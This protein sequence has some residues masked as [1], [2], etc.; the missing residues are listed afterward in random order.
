M[1]PFRVFGWSRSPCKSTASAH[2]GPPGGFLVGFRNPVWDHSGNLYTDRLASITGCF[3]AHSF[4]NK[5]LV[6]TLVCRLLKTH[7][8][9]RFLL[10]NPP[11]NRFSLPAHHA[12]QRIECFLHLSLVPRFGKSL[13]TACRPSKQAEQNSRL[14]MALSCKPCSIAQYCA[15]QTLILGSQSILEGASCSR[16]QVSPWQ[17]Y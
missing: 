13:G 8:F 11:P 5:R 7:Q 4:L 2:T 16:Y 1:R 9:L 10:R 17:Q 3:P 14:S 12:R 6:K 15:S